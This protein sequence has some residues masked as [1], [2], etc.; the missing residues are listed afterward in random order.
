MPNDPRLR[1]RLRSLVDQLGPLL[2]LIGVWSLF[3]FM[4]WDIFP[5]W[6][7]TQSILLQTAVIG[8]AAL[9]GTMVIISGG[10]DLSVGSLIALVS[11]AVALVLRRLGEAGADADG[12]WHGYGAAA[13]AAALGVAVAGLCGL[14][15]GT[16]VI[17][18]VGRIAALIIGCLAGLL[19]WRSGLDYRGA[20]PLA[21]VVA[22]GAW[23]GESKLNLS[24]PLSPFIVT[25]GM[26]GAL[27]GAAKG[28]AD[29]SAVYPPPTPLNSLMRF[30]SVANDASLIFQ[31]QHWWSPGVWI[32]LALACLIAGLLRYTQFGRHIYAIGSNEQTARLCGIPIERVKLKIYACAALL[33]GVAG[34]LQFSF[35][36]VGDPT[37]AASYELGVIAAAV[38]GGASLS[39]G[40]GTILGTVAGALLMSTIN[41]GCTKIGLEVWMQEIVTGAIIVTAVT[42]DKLR[43]RGAG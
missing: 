35:V 14:S 42:L 2:A 4:R 36:E 25:L 27:R 37:T 40:V 19:A 28:L 23:W 17:G 6:E 33:T 38:I 24:I 3:A 21:A 8:I 30:P 5:T 26:W 43:H 41:N 16:M 11:V 31:P 1:T 22:A 15:I 13:L 39:G 7:N 18:R 32:F 20:L 10:I 29:N 9:G 34:V 12:D